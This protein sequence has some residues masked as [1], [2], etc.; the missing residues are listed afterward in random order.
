MSLSADDIRRIFKEESGIALSW[1]ERRQDAMDVRLSDLDKRVAGL[2]KNGVGRADSEPRKSQRL[3][4]GR[5]H[6]SPPSL[7]FPL[8]DDTVKCNGWPSTTLWD[9]IK[10]HLSRVLTEAGVDSQCAVVVLQKYGNQGLVRVDD[11]AAGIRLFEWW[12][13][14]PPKRTNFVGQENLVYARWRPSR[15]ITLDEWVLRKTH[16]YLRQAGVANIEKEQGPLVIYVGAILFC[17]CIT[18]GGE[19]PLACQSLP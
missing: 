11:H 16:A 18:V 4:S 10:E 6:S 7:A 12:R 14:N 15:E 1:L 2:E 5:P 13:V 17:E 19:W 3:A 8:S 9:H